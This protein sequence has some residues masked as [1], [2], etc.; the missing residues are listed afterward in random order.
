MPRMPRPQ[1]IDQLIAYLA[2]H[3]ASAELAREIATVR[4]MREATTEVKAA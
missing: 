2:G 4:R 1:N 3:P